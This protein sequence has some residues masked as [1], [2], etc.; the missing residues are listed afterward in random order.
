VGNITFN[1]L[2]ADGNVQRQDSGFSTVQIAWKHLPEGGTVKITSDGST[3]PWVGAYSI[4][5]ARREPQFTTSCPK[6]GTLTTGFTG[7]EVNALS[8]IAS[9][10]NNGGNNITHSNAVDIY[11]VDMN[12]STG[13]P[14]IGVECRAEGSRANGAANVVTGVGGSNYGCSVLATWYED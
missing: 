8:L 6:N 9:A 1:G 2:S 11:E 7:A 3:E 12:G 14:S 4:I 13:G 10:A 5:T